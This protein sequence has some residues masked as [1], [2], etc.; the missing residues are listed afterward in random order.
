MVVR[1]KAELTMKTHSEFVAHAMRYALFGAAFV[2]LALGLG[3]L[4][5]HAIGGLGWVDAF[6]NASMILT[7][8]GPVDQMPDDASK[9]FASLYAIFG[10]AVYPAVTAIV[11]YPFCLLYTS[12]STPAK[13]LTAGATRRSKST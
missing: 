8:M 3:V 12:I 1:K 10:G 13:S 11:L 6:L 5:Y 7:A 4:G 2:V 9:I